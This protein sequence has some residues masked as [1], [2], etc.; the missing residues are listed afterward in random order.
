V[1]EPGPEPAVAGRTATAEAEGGDERL[2]RRVRAAYREEVDRT[3]ESLLNA[4][5][6]FTLTFGVLLGLTYAIKYP[7]V[8]WGDLVAGGVHLHHYVWGVALLLVVA[9]SR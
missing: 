4:A 7:L 8:P 9:W 2:S 5:I 1:P 6:A 3:H